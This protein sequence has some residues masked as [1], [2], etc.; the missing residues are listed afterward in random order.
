MIF[1]SSKTLSSVNSN[2]QTAKATKLWLVAFERSLRADFIPHI[3]FTF[4]R[5]NSRDIRVFVQAYAP[6]IILLLLPSS[7]TFQFS[8]LNGQ[9][10]K[11]LVGR[12]GKI[13][14]SSFHTLY[15]FCI[16]KQNQPSQKGFGT[17]VC[18]FYDFLAF[19]IFFQLSFLNG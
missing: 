2:F 6:F 8:F 5:K 16:F 3:V 15:S 14:L 1:F 9:S 12:V 7:S 19:T 11:T 13:S 18:L 4:S 17:T 10:Y